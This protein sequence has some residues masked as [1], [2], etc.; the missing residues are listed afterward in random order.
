LLL[1]LQFN[2]HGNREK[3][4]NR[5]QLSLSLWWDRL[6]N[7]QQESPEEI[8]KLRP[9]NAAAAA[10]GGSWSFSPYKTK[11]KIEAVD[12]FRTNVFH[13]IT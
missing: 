6:Q 3:S 5:K 12:V 13:I 10:G 9:W 2:F 4:A 1:G 7:Q 8:D 11:Q